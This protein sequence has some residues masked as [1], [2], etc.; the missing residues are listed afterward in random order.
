MYPKKN[1]KKHLANYVSLIRDKIE[2][3]VVWSESL[4]N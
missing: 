3:F 2:Q 1:K 4:I